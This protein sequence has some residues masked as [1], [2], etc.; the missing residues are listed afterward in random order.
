MALFVGRIP[1]EMNN[2]DLEDA[3]SKYGKITR[4]DVKTGFGFVEYDDKRDAEDAI[5]GINEKGELVVEWAKNGGK[6]PGENECFHCGKEGHWARDCL[7]AGREGAR[8]GGRDSGRGGRGGRGG[9]RG[10]FGR[11]R[12]PRRDGGRGNDRDRSLWFRDNRGYERRRDDRDDRGG[13]DRSPRRNDYR[14]R[15]DR[16]YER[17]GGNDRRDDRGDRRDYAPRE[18]RRREEERMASERNQLE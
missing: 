10:G 17:R 11:D 6:R 16:G 12:S 15:N 14:E 8:D 18:D 1:R 7:E 9:S 13:R 4:L 5:K 3:F 2:R